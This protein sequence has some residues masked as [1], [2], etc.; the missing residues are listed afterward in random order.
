MNSRHADNLDTSILSQLAAQ[1]MEAYPQ[2]I[3]RAHV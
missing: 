1:A 3:G 2:E